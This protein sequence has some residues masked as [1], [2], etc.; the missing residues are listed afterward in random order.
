[1]SPE[2][3]RTVAGILDDTSTDPGRVTLELTES[4][5]VDDA[6]RAL[7]VLDEL[8]HLGVRLALDDFGSGYSSLSYLKRFPVD[9]VKVDRGFVADLAHDPAT[10][11]IVSAVV[12][13]THVLG[14]AVVAEG[15]ETVEQHSVVDAL[16][17]EFCQGFYL[18]RP[19]PADDVD[20]L[21][22]LQGPMVCAYP[23]KA[24]P[25]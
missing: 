4:V 24:D 9:I 13:M 16:G 15:V 14:I 21:L 3:A 8:T 11:V 17:C 20:R 25:S 2:F 19:M 18:A 22:K 5:F 6:E 23:V 1:M 10:S 12:V 7:V